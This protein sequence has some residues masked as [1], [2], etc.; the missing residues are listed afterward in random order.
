MIDWPFTE[1]NQN[2]IVKLNTSIKQSNKI[3]DYNHLLTGLPEQS[4]L[5]LVE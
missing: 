3:Y 2:K 4:N 1:I 5:K